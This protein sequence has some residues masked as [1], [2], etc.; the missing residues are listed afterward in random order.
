MVVM[1][2]YSPE[3]AERWMRSAVGFSE[4][5]RDFTKT[6]LWK[7]AGGDNTNYT[8]WYNDW[9]PRGS[10]MLAATKDGWKTSGKR[11][12]LTTT[13]IMLFKNKIGNAHFQDTPS[14]PA[15]DMGLAG[16]S[17]EIPFEQQL[18]TAIDIL[19]KRYGTNWR[20]H[21]SLD[22]EWTS[23]PEWFL[24][25]RLEWL[26]DSNF[27]YYCNR[28]GVSHPDDP[29][30]IGLINQTDKTIESIIDLALKQTAD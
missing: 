15:N 21:N 17:E 16:I 11:H 9:G 22:M 18:G 1:P 20:G 26:V 14:P 5:D 4:L 7:D 25:N 30:L 27:Y 23:W 2:G 8:A 3:Q 6:E 29:H 28:D 24:L 10:K 13:G 12:K 19:I